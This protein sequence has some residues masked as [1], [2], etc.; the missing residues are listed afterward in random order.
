MKIVNEIA[1]AD[2]QDVFGTQRREP[3]SNFEMKNRRLRF[4]DAQLNHGNV[5]LG[6][7]VAEHRPSSVIQPPGVV[8]LHRH[9]Y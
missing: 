6:E 2:N 1:A 9:W 3:S 5:G 8:Q 7:Y 4:I